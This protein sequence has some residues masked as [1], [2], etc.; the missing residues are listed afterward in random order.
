[1]HLCIR[2]LVFLQPN[3]PSCTGAVLHSERTTEETMSTG[4]RVRKIVRIGH[5]G[6]AKKIRILGDTL[7]RKQLAD[8]RR[9]LFFPAPEIDPV[10]I[11]RS[12]MR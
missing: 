12:I 6:G 11:A 9:N 4:R 10:I 5:K 1:M 7:I 8:Q 3:S 2:A